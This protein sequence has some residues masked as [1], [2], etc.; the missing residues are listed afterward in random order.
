MAEQDYAQITG[1][2]IVGDVGPDKAAELADLIR[3]QPNTPTTGWGE[4]VVE[5]GTVR[6]MLR[7]G[8]MLGAWPDDLR[9]ALAKLIAEVGLGG[10]SDVRN[11]ERKVI[12]PRAEYDRPTT[13][14]APTPT[15]PPAEEAEAE[16]VPNMSTEQAATYKRMGMPP[17]A[18]FGEPVL[19]KVG[20][21]VHAI[22]PDGQVA[23][24]ED[25]RPRPYVG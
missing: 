20:S 12:M 16:G 25:G 14:D 11:T 5:G 15:P 10:P 7:R 8:P 24:P 13:T 3:R 17:V 4:P 18:R 6:A 23:G 22:Y 21:A 1:E 9:R 2:C 19:V